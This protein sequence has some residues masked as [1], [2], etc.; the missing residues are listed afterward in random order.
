MHEFYLTF[1]RR[2]LPTGTATATGTGIATAT[3]TAT[4]GHAATASASQQ[5]CPGAP[6]LP[7]DVCAE[8]AAPSSYDVVVTTYE[9]V[10]GEPSG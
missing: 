10:K 9:M 8:S 6:L 3:A 1:F 4:F 2:C 7:R 5:R